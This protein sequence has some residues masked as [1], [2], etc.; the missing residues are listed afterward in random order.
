[1]AILCDIDD[2]EPG[3]DGYGHGLGDDVVRAFAAL[4]QTACPTAARLG[5]PS[6]RGT[7]TSSGGQSVRRGFRP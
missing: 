7:Q 6:A 3:N 2:F 1:M 5:C 4:L